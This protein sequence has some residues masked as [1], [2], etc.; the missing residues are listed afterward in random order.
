V[1]QYLEKNHKYRHVLAP[2]PLAAS[3][4][5]RPYLNNHNALINAKSNSVAFF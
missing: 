4:L 5:F 1:R 2:V 3:A